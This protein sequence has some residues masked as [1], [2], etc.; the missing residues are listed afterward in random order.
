MQFPFKE[1]GRFSLRPHAGWAVVFMVIAAGVGS[2]AGDWPQWGGPDPGR[3]MVSGETG[4]PVFFRPGVKSAQG[5][6][7]VSGS[8]EH[9]RWAVRL[10]SYLYGNP[11]V[12]AGRV[13]VGT[14]DSILRGDTRLRPT[15]G[16]MVQCLDEA[17]GEVR[18]RLRT[19]NRGEDRLPPG[20]HYGQQHCGTCSSPAVAG[21]RAYVLSSACEVVCLDVDGL[22]NGND[23][24]FRDEGR[25]LVGPGKRPVPVQPGDAD[26]V[27]VCDL[28]DALGVCPHDVASC[29]VLVDGRFVYTVT[30][31][32]VD[33]PHAKCPRPDAPSFV[34]L[35]AETGRVLA[36]DAEGMGRRLWHCLWAPPSLGTVN[37][38]RLVFFGGGDGVCYA[39]EALT[40][41][42]RE[43]VLLKKVWHYDCNP[44]EY[45]LR[46]G[47]PIPYYAGDKR[48]ANSANK[49]DGLYL[50]P[51]QIIATPVFHDGRLY[52]AIGQ[53]PMHGR[54]RGLLHCIDPSKTGDIT[55]TGR[56]WSY[57]GIERTMASVA[58]A[59]GRL[60]AADLSGRVHCLDVATGRPLWT[61]D[62]KA[63]TWA[64]PLVADGK[65]YVGTKSRLMVLAAGPEPRELARISLG[66][67]AYGT[68]VAANGTLFVASQ[69]YLWAAQQDA[70]FTGGMPGS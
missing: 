45:R 13:F 8:T 50:G 7:I 40:D 5:S 17:T 52:V 26:I 11:T 44:P 56:V 70:R 58:I 29:S 15:K 55:R 60:Y 21:R 20:A 42:P 59:D 12:S 16:G 66:A 1:V 24:P 54:G 4:L 28:V 48:K 33:G 41:V 32:G 30:S 63:E 69:Q 25:Y 14:D 65:I 2:R 38:R 6:G 57:D 61:H 34:A 18:W 27:W 9:V 23:G 47:K 31:N 3:N 39:F 43:P 62:L 68:P 67:P 36:T 53:D 19:P 49:N 22:A 37:G 10:G 35:D 46:D 64:T 51:S